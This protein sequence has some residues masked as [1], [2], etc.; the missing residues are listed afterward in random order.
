MDRGARQAT[1]HGI[2]KG[3]TQLSDNT[4]SVTTLRPLTVWITKTV[5]N[6]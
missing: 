6:S 1:V 5:E 2:G 3:Q 4:D